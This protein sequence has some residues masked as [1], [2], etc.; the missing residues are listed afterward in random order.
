M[1]AEA[2]RTEAYTGRLTIL[3]HSLQCF[4]TVGWA[5]SSPNDLLWDVKPYYTILKNSPTQFWQQLLLVLPQHCSV[6]IVYT[7][8]SPVM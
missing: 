2:G 6:Q 1:V 8:I 4:D 7:P 3:L 5:R